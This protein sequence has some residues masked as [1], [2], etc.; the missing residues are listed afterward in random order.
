MS[1]PSEEG[2]VPI[3]VRFEFMNANEELDLSPPYKVYLS[4][5]KNK[6]EDFDEARIN[7]I[8]SCDFRTPEER[9][10]YYMFN[11]SRKT[12][13]KKEDNISIYINNETNIKL[14][15]FFLFF[16]LTFNL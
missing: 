12:F 1:K 5:E 4:V 13:I 7:I 10:Y 11:K 14:K 6:F 9:C 15:L 16:C 3:T 2:G 8:N